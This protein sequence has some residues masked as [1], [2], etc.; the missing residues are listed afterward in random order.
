MANENYMNLRLLTWF[1]Y[2]LEKMD[3]LIPIFASPH[4]SFDPL[5]VRS[6]LSR[7]SVCWSSIRDAST[8][9]Q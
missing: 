7:T 4:T 5:S 1:Y 6:G 3:L 2:Y 8:S 9:E